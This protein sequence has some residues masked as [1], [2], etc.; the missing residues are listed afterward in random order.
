MKK[1]LL[2][3][4]LLA[5]V[6]VA[7]CSKKSEFRTAINRSIE[8]DY[9]CLDLKS[10][11][12]VPFMDN[13]E[14]EQYKKNNDYVI[15]DEDDSSKP[16]RNTSHDSEDSDLTRA[17]ALVKAGLL[18]KTVKRE[19]AMNAANHKPVQSTVFAIHLYNLTAAGKN[20]IRAKHFDGFFGSGDRKYTFCYAHPEVDSIMNFSEFDYNGQKAAQVKYSYK[21][22]DVADWAQSNEIKAAF[23][24]LG[25]QLDGDTTANVSEILLIKTN[26]GWQ[27]H[28]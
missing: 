17:E 12:F 14:L 26:N 3:G 21:L 4:L 16:H 27:T 24:E 6:A 1:S 9:N 22:A 25:K 20:S 13:K 10:S 5:G 11:L 19:Q 7:G 18:T 15:V 8:K 23:P 2:L 28:L